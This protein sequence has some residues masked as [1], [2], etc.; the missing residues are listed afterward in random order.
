[1]AS[2]VKRGDSYRALVRR[3]GH[4]HCK[5]FGS[6]KAAQD[7]A[8]K[9]EGEIDELKGSGVM[10]PKGLTIGDLID[11]YIRELYPVKPWGRSKA[12]DLASLKKTFGH[13]PAGELTGQHITLA[14]QKRAAAGAGPVTISASIGYLVGVLT[15]AR[16]LWHLDV[17]LQAAQDARTALCTVK[18]VGKSKRRDRRVSDA[19]ITRIIEYFEKFRSSL[20]YAD[21]VRFLL[22]TGMRLSEA[23]RLRWSDLNEQDKT[24]TIRDRKHPTEKIGNDM[25]VPLLNATGFD[26]FEIL[27]R[28][29]RGGKYVFNF[30]PHTV[31]SIF[32]RALARIEGIED[33]H[34]HD[35]RHEAITRLFKAGYRI[36]Q[37]ALVSGHRDWAMLKR[38][39]HVQAT[40]LHRP[41]PVPSSSATSF[42]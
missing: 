14:Y 15:V 5:T 18:L 40:D 25:V 28:Q 2:I 13:I 36:E 34:L 24:I 37:V 31:S 26:A 27:M 12:A 9:V 42:R 39:T 38:Y 23:C 29:P 10:Q 33:L 7:W 22:A 3:A 41:A 20:P 19:E 6:R 11:R 35:L 4:K 16:T 17:P 32:P 30:Q 21:L 8:K 1:M